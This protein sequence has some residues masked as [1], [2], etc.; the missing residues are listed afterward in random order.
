MGASGAHLPDPM[1]E[2]K[3]LKISRPKIDMCPLGSAKAGR[4]ADALR[5]D[6]KIIPLSAWRS[7]Q[8]GAD[9]SSMFKALSFLDR[10]VL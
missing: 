10:F 2:V 1:S 4:K 8:A 6:S 5:N 3:G 9:A 7:R